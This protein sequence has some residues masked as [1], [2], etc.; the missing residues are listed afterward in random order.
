MHGFLHFTNFKNQVGNHGVFMFKIV[1][2][3]KIVHWC[4]LDL[5][6]GLVRKCAIAI[7]PC[8]GT[9]G[10]FVGAGRITLVVHCS[11]VQRP[12]ESK[13]RK[14]HRR[15]VSGRTLGRRG[16]AEQD[17]P[18]IEQFPEE[19]SVPRTP[20]GIED[21]SPERLSRNREQAK[22]DVKRWRNTTSGW[23]AVDERLISCLSPERG[24]LFVPG[25]WAVDRRFFNCKPFSCKACLKT[26]ANLQC[27]SSKKTRF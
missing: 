9:K 8:R 19:T 18:P 10:C 20:Q 21:T 2:R 3:E 11:K 25:C 1:V 27:R 4:H 12:V 5:D 22:S 15:V 13:I 26:G 14:H 16:G 7:S 23:R 24:A 17:G 6:F